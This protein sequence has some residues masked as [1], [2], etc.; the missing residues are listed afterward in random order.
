MHFVD[1][2]A[3]QH[4]H[5]AVRLVQIALVELFDYHVFLRLQGVGR[6]VQSGHAVCFEPKGGFYVVLRQ[7]DVVVRVVVVREGVVLA[8]SHL[9]RQIEVGDLLGAAEHQMLEKVRKPRM[10]GIFVAC[11]YAVKNVYGCHAG[12][13]VAMRQNPEPVVQSLC[14]VAYHLSVLFFMQKYSFCRY[15][16]I[17]VKAVCG[18]RLRFAKKKS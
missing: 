13:R 11:A 5:V 18:K 17:P 4:P 9:Q 15:R 6:Y 14:A 2:P 16:A 1:H 10:V 12:A 7:G 8:A 3:Q